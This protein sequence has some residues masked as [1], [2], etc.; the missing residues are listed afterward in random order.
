MGKRIL[1]QGSQGQDLDQG[2]NHDHQILRLYR[3][4][5]EK[6]LF[7][8]PNSMEYN[9]HLTLSKKV[10][11]QPLCWV[12]F[13][14]VCH[15]LLSILYYK[16]VNQPHLFQKNINHNLLSKKK[17]KENFNEYIEDAEN[18][19]AIEEEEAAK[20]VALEEEA[21]RRKALEEKDDEAEVKEKDNQKSIKKKAQRSD[22]KSLVPDA[23]KSVLEDTDKTKTIFV[24]GYIEKDLDACEVETKVQ[25]QSKY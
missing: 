22:T 2:L 15:Q 21:A 10:H 13:K 25:D 9:L 19:K 16:Q 4:K 11:Q 23:S 20:K 17:R 5:R 14:G 6:K 18:K 1:C 3:N 24:P 7:K 12:C 8:Q